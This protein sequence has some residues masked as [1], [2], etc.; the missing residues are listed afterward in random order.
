MDH[1]LDLQCYE[2]IYK[3]PVPGREQRGDKSEIKNVYMSRF[4]VGPVYIQ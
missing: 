1:G 2:S 4:G 3:S